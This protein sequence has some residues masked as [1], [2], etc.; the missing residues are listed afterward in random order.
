MF[1]DSDWAY[2]REYLSGGTAYSQ[3]AEQTLPSVVIVSRQVGIMDFDPG[4]PM[5]TVKRFGVVRRKPEL[6]TDTLALNWRDDHAPLFAV[7]SYLRRYYIHLT[8]RI[9]APDVA[10]DGYA[11]IWWD[12][13]ASTKLRSDTRVP[14]PES[15][16]ASE[17]V[18]MFMTPKVVT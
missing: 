1:F 10:W 7:N 5:P 14:Q 2:E 15:S 18:Y 12:D 9:Y 17:V 11:E 13:F 16:D 3:E 6:N 4:R 8:D